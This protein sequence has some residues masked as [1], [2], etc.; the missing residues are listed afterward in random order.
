[1]WN[2]CTNRIIIFNV[3]TG[4]A[5]QFNQLCDIHPRTKVDFVEVL[6]ETGVDSCQVHAGTKVELPE[7]KGLFPSIM[8]LIFASINDKLRAILGVFITVAIL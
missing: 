1:M 4:T 8:F 2:P 6:E 5:V 7:I 3:H